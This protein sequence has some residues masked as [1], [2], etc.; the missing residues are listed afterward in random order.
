MKKNQ[1]R[2]ESFKKTRKSH[3]LESAEDYTELISELIAAHGVA[4]T[5]AIAEAL[6]V[7][8]VTA[9]R[10]I[11][12]LQREG[13]VNTKPHQPVE[14]TPKGHKLAAFCLHRHRVVEDFL[15][16]IGVSAETA[17]VDSEGIEHHISP[18]TLE[19]LSRVPGLYQA[20]AQ[21]K[22]R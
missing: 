14:L 7:S 20:T 5:G 9:L 1:A 11:Q 12:R 17:A 22:K 3:A 2:A 4:R 15:L 6:G 16:R 21:K 18:E 19:C 10:T 13:Y 8:H